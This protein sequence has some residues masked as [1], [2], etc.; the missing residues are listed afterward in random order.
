MVSNT[1]AL[2]R[3][4]VI[5]WVIDGTFGMFLQNLIRL[6]MC[7]S[8]ISYFQYTCDWYIDLGSHIRMDGHIEER[9]E[10]VSYVS[11][12]SNEDY[13]DE[14]KSVFLFLTPPVRIRTRK[15]GIPFH[16]A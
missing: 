11:A 16:S 5:V 3:I 10:T 2:L 7:T 1:F 4:L 13:S 8:H 9:R 12:A 14:R 6:A 15:R